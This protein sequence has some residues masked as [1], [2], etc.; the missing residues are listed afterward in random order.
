MK[1]MT[2]FASQTV[3]TDRFDLY[4]EIKSVNSRYFDFKFKAVHQLNAV[5][6]EI[7]K[8]VQE[9]LHRGKVDLYIK[10]TEKSADQYEVVVNHELAKKYEEAFRHLSREISILSQV[11]VQDFIALEGLMSIE[12]KEADEELIQ[13]VFQTLSNALNQMNEMMES[14]GQK[15]VEDI[16]SSLSTISDA[17]SI[18]AERYPESLKTYKENFKNRLQEL[19][20]TTID[21]NRLLMETEI[22]AGKS[23][24]NEEL[25]RLNSHLHQFEQILSG[26]QNGDAK[27]L[28][29]VSQEMN[30]ETN[31]IASKSSDSE[32][33]RQTIT[34][35]GEIEKI[36]E[37]LRN[38][39]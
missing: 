4:L 26:K 28:D 27:K 16:S 39:V 31:T 14:E 38:L 2:G 23:A 25:V 37:Q 3:T 10:I 11:S 21:E 35:K 7:K 9:Y 15:T 32:I 8:K 20:V 13:T 19:A 34:I 17:V 30:R 22:I 36:R 18:I 33:I 12:R 5:E 6:I 24:I 29:F 1:S